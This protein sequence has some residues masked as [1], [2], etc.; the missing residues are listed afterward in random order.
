M[1]NK[2]NSLKTENK[3]WLIYIFIFIFALI[4]NY[5]EEN[6]LYTNNKKS[7]KIYQSI[8]LTILTTAL[9]IYFY[10][11]VTDYKQINQNKYGVLKE[12]ASLMFFIAGVIVIYIEYKT[13][14]DEEIGII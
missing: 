5:F 2:L 12:T 11:V 13:Q 14:N 8:N 1:N 6:Y 3:I 9:I 10:F 7:K 4:S